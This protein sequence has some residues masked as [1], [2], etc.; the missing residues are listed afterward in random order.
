MIP[1]ALTL[2][3]IADLDIS[4]ASGLLARGDELITI[5]DDELFAAVFD[6]HGALRRRIALL[7]GELPERHAERKRQKPDFESLAS[8]PDGRVLA[9]GSGS[10]RTR[11]RSVCFDPALPGDHVTAD[12]SPLYAALSRT[13]PELNIEGAAVQSDRLWLAQRGNGPSGQNACIEL[14]LDRVRAAFVAREPITARALIAVHPVRLGR[15]DGTAL[16][17]TDLAPHPSTDRLLFSA[18]AEPSASTY[19]DAPTSGSAIGVLDLRGAVVSEHRA[20]P[21]CKLEGIALSSAGDA[22]WLV[23]DPDDRA[24]RAPLFRVPWPLR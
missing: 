8:L 16:S 4:A 2:S 22:L 18:A 19:D 21:V 11:M 1:P 23:A 5:A 17:L 15:I 9:L 3:K 20:T 10:T 13:M 7:A 14:D 24:Q 12:W 6:Q